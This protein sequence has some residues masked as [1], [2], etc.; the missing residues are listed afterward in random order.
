MR[1]RVSRASGL[2]IFRPVGSCVLNFPI[3]VEKMKDCGAKYFFVEQDNAA[4]LPDPMGA[5]ERSICYIKEQL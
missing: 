1:A 3:I 5:V 4:T 2:P